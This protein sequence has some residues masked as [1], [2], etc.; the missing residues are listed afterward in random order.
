MSFTT[1]SIFL[2]FIFA[3]PYNAETSIPHFS[4]EQIQHIIQ[5]NRFPHMNLILRL[6]HV[7]KQEFQHQRTSQSA[8]F[9]L[10]IGK[11][12]RQID[13]FYRINSDKS[14]IR[15]CLWEPVSL[16]RLWCRASMIR[17]FYTKCFPAHILITGFPVPAAEPTTLIT[18]EFNFILLTFW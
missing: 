15:H 11:S 18:Q 5:I 8:S 7:I 12:H 4:S 9:N 13:V 14:R 3:S 17:C 16:F 2:N 6:R 10:E 1:M